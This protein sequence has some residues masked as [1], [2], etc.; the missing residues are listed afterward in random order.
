MD[1]LT[2]ELHSQ[3]FRRLVL[4]FNLFIYYS[5]SPVM[6]S[7][8]QV[9]GLLVQMIKSIPLKSFP[10]YPGQRECLTHLSVSQLH[11][12]NKVKMHQ[13]AEPWLQFQV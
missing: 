11:C 10:K 2:K 4:F 5:G 6:Q 8:L 3:T 7:E 13:S 9:T 1:L 12:F